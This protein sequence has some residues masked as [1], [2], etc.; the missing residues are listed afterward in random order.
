MKFTLNFASILILFLVN[1]LIISAAPC[2]SF[3]FKTASDYSVNGSVPFIKSDFNKDG[4]IDLA[5]IT[6][7]SISILLGDGVGGFALRKTVDISSYTSDLTSG[8]FNNDGNIDIALTSSNTGTVRVLLGAGDGTFGSPIFSSLQLNIY[9]LTSSDFNHDGN[10]DL[11]VLSIERGIAYILF[12]NGM[13]SFTGIID[14]P[15]ATS[16]GVKP[17][18]AD[19]NNDGSNDIVIGHDSAVWGVSILFNNGNGGFTVQKLVPSRYFNSVVV[20]D[21]NG[22]NNLDII[23]GRIN[24]SN[25]SVLYGLGNGTFNDPVI[26]AEISNPGDLAVADFDGDNKLDIAATREGYKA[27]T[28]LYGD[29]F[30][31]FSQ[32]ISFV[33]SP[34][35]SSRRT[36]LTADFNGDLLPDI[37]TGGEVI[38]VRFNTGSNRKFLGSNNF[39]VGITPSGAAIG[40]LNNDGKQ[41]LAVSNHTSGNVSILIGDGVGNFKDPTNIKIGN[42]AAIVISDFNEDGN[43]DLA[44]ATLTN[45]SI[46][47]L[48]G[49]GEGTFAAPALFAVGNSP[50]AIAVSDF[51]ADNH[52]DLV[53]ANYYGH[54]VSVLIGNGSGSFAPAASYTVGINPYSVAI[55]DFNNDGKNDIVSGNESSNFI[56]L[57]SNIGNGIFSPAININSGN[58][59]VSVAVNDF[60]DDGN[61]DLA[62]VNKSNR[63][64]SIIFGSGA[65]TFSS[66]LSYA[67]GGNPYHVTVGKINGDNKLDLV[68]AYEFGYGISLFRGTGNGQFAP[69]VAMPAG[70]SPEFT[71][72]GDLNNDGK[73]DVVVVNQNDN[74][75]LVLINETPF[76][77]SLLGTVTYGITSVNQTPKFVPRVLLSASGATSTSTTSGTTGFYQLEE[78]TANEAYTVTPIKTGNINGITPFDATLVLRCVAAGNAC[79]LTPNQRMAADTNNSG[80]VTAFD[81]T[82]ILRFVAANQQTANTGQ[83][84][85]W[86]FLPEK[87]DY[88]SLPSTL[89]DQNYKAILIGEINGDWIP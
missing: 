22:D 72:V 24:E 56:S 2:T 47:V 42:A 5:T 68:V 73:S 41:D 82:Q 49:N 50:R 31:G 58:N 6:T 60:N 79:A 21:F 33:V 39:L 70:N 63:T 18:I 13:G 55:G 20:V 34:I 32:L 48:L 76:C 53:V 7:N 26:V 23:G 78:L 8:D 52:L 9:R 45:N 84:G 54:T 67:T 87:R 40:D 19:L 35:P 1:V 71:T 61:S 30:G 65:N 25:I 3:D 80:D 36:I 85:N 64:V 11:V 66:P 4:K 28:I 51:N 10:L 16:T 37:S 88:E 15:I 83:I 62:F 59:P 14:Y 27:V 86:K 44:A 29:G 74:N 75:I 57:L 43:Q 81:A 38:S 69:A 46:T 89:S 77:V 17:V 12:G